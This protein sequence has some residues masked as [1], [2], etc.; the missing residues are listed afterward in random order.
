[1][2]IPKNYKFKISYDH[3]Y[4]PYIVEYVDVTES[5]PDLVEFSEKLGINY[6][7]LK[8]YN[9]WLRQDKLTVRGNKKYLIAIPV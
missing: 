1:M 6:K 8:K 9:P 5:I 2:K 7:Q 4:N 3:F